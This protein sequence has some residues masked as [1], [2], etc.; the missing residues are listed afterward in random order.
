M[1]RLFL[2]SLLLVSVGIAYASPLIQTDPASVKI[3]ASMRV[4]PTVWNDINIP[5]SALTL[6][7]AAPDSI[8]IL[9]AGGIKSMGFDGNA[10]V[11]SVHGSTEIIHGYAEGTDIYPHIHWMPTT[12]NAGNVK[13]QLEY[14]WQN[15]D[16]VFAD[17]TT[18]FSISTSAG[19]AW[20]SQLDFFPAVDG[21]G[22]DHGSAFV[23]RLFRDPTDGA[24][25]YNNDDAAAIQVGIHYEVDALGSVTQGSKF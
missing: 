24:D 20:T 17:P 22:K 3:N 12:A 13:W 1:K 18:T 23:F 4:V 6:G 21:T 7:A 10:T 16:G 5:I 8:G 19:T 9:G 11:E 2:A 14:S 15:I 25:T